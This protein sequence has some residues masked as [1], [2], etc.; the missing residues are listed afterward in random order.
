MP[1][2]VHSP[3]RAHPRFECESHGRV[4]PHDQHCDDDDDGKTE[5]GTWI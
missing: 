3:P 5:T 4:L 1:V 2:H